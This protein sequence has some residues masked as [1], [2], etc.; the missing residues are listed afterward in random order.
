MRTKTIARW[1]RAALAGTLAA[2]LTAPVAHAQQQPAP[3]AQDQQAQP[4]AQDQQAPPAQD[5]Q[6][7]PAAQDQQAPPAAQETQ[8]QQAPPPAK[9]ETAPVVT[10]QSPRPPPDTNIQPVPG[11]PEQYVIQKGDTL[12]DLS[13]KFL[14]NPWYWPKIWSNNP[15]IENPHWIYPGNKLR[16]VPGEGGAQAPA[17]VQ[18]PPEPGVDATAANAPVEGPPDV[19]AD[20]TPPAS[21]DLDVVSKSSREGNSAL[22]TVS[23]SGKLAFSPPSVVTVRSSGLVSPEDLAAAGA[24]SASFEEKEML[25]TYDTGYVKFKGEAPVKPGDK[26][27]AFHTVGDIVDPKSH[28]KLAIQTETTAVLKVLSVRGD[29]VTVQVERAFLEVG[30]GDLVRP[31]TAQEKRLAPR[32]NT[33]EVTGMIVQ[34]VTPGITTIGESRE[35]F[36]DKGSVDGV[37]EGNTFAVVRHGD[38]LSERAVTDSYAGGGLA[39]AAATVGVPDENVGL[40]LV[41]DTTEH[42]STAIVIKS[43]RELIAGDKVEMHTSGGGG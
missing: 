30:R 23:A 20:V 41:V 37:Q 32:P 13:Q 39:A 15:Y 43:V 36:I 24:L 6:A 33:T 19:G 3:A 40:L 26:L 25:S 14:N 9:N 5:Q 18:A 29:S 17:Q 22:N 28:K 7:P 42:L 1:R 12:W 27:L 2:T 38:G 21:P 4:A 16:I 31:W 10:E 11:T 8:P 35:V 34:A